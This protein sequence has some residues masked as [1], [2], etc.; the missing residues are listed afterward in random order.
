MGSSRNSPVILI[1]D[2][3]LANSGDAAICTAMTLMLRR[4]IPG[5]KVVLASH[6][7]ELVG[8][9]YPELDLVPP[10]D[11]LAGVR[12]PWTSE[13]DLAER[14][15][16]AR[17]VEEADVAIA[18]GGGYMVERYDPANR[19][20]TYEELLSR[21]KRLMLYSQ[22][23][24]EFRNPELGG[25]LAAVLRAAELVLVRDESS[26]QVVAEQRGE[27]GVH[28]T[29]DEAFLFPAP[30]RVS[31][32]R[33]LLLTVA[34]HPWERRDGVNELDDRS[35]L[36]ALGAAVGR[37]LASGTAH[38]ITLAS[39]TQGLGDTGL[40]LEDD[41]LAAR[42]VLA[43][44]PAQ[45]R[46]RVV[47]R[48]DYLTAADYAELAARHTAAVSM[49]MHGTILAAVAGTPAL[50][51]NASDKARGLSARTGGK[52]EAIESHPDLDRFDELIGD[53]LVA[54]R[55]P[56]LRQN[57]GVEQMR[58]QARRNSELVARAL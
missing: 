23:F 34:A 26:L 49:R 18:A 5:A 4:A 39:T 19:I 24:G 50:L 36:P 22:S 8:N 16:I 11:A 52:L 3:W 2:G 17:V 58:T 32:Y 12:W 56:V 53:T 51:A 29:A 45:W 21:G 55:K 33:S 13:A 9:R 37:L 7:R 28:L 41:A 48:D 15:V 20:T 31:R 57:E 1:T 27:E 40:A 10:L 47:L 42:E 6:H 46:N 30:R 43:A 25:R 35:H 38:S 14:D 44:V 54:P